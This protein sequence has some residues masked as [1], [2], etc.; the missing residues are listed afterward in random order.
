MYK[1]KENIS[2]KRMIYEIRGKQVMLDSDLGKLYNTETKRINE[3]VKR[4]L[5]RFPEEFCFKINKEELVSLRSQIATL[6]IKKGGKGLH[7]K[8]L[9]YVFT[10]HGIMMLAGLLKSDVAARVNVNIIK[11]FVEMRKFINENKELFKKMITIENTLIE[12][13]KNFEIIFDKFDRK[14]DL[15][16]K[17]FYNGEIYDAYSLFIDIVSNAEKE[18]VIIDN[19]VDKQVLDIL[20]K[21]KINVMVILI[22]DENKSKLINT[23]INKFNDQYPSLKIK[24]TNM[25]HD[26]FI[27]ID[28]KELYHIGSSLKDLG[29][30]VFAISKINDL[31]IIENLI[32]KL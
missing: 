31:E 18:I 32:N 26:R 4:N 23:D 22:T 25:F 12:H 28:N 9:P 6:E 16:S 7:S 15:K 30:K 20:S 24:Y 5:N 13:D 21:K 14:E 2:I 11:A 19:Y 17:L 3:T 27:I 1:I 29:K 10:E 8:Y